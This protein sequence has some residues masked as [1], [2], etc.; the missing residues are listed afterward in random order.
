MTKPKSDNFENKK[1]SVLSRSIEHAIAAADNDNFDN[2]SAAEIIQI[3]DHKIKINQVAYTLVLDHAAGFDRQRLAMRY[4]DVLDKYDYIV[5]DWGYGQLRLRG[6]Y[7]VKRS[8]A[9]IDQKINTLQ[10]YLLEYCNFGCAYFVLER[11]HKV[12]MDSSK[13]KKTKQ[14]N[15]SSKAPK[16]VKFKIRNLDK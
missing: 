14:F 6:F 15:R 16:E 7:D 4:N 12:N 5:G 2:E 10:D 1:Q 8:Q 3:N 13:N 9:K 11:D